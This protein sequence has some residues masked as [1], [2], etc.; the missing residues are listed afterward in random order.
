[1]CLAATIFVVRSFGQQFQ[2]LFE[3]NLRFRLLALTDISCAIVGAGAAIGC[4]LGGLGVVSL[5]IGQL[6][7]PAPAPL[8]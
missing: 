4:A 7:T 2:M 8:R 3:K 1:M 6:S 5:I